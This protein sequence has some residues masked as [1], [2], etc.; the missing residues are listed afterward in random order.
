MPSFEAFLKARKEKL[1]HVFS[2]LQIST[3]ESL[4]PPQPLSQNPIPSQPLANVS[5]QEDR[6][7]ITALSKGVYTIENVKNRNWAVLAND[8]DRS[9]VI[10]GTSADKGAG[11]KVNLS[12]FTNNSLAKSYWVVGTRTNQ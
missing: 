2:S 10:A 4:V 6:L 11:E 1:R 9:D 7:P 8:D 12:N 5:N 3:P